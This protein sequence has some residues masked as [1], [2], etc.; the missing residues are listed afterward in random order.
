MFVTITSSVFLLKPSSAFPFDS[1]FWFRRR[2]WCRCRRRCR[3]R[4][5]CLQDVFLH[6]R[7][8]VGPAEHWFKRSTQVVLHRA[9]QFV[10]F[11]RHDRRDAKQDEH[12]GLDWNRG[13]HDSTEEAVTSGENT[14]ILVFSLT[15]APPVD[16]IDI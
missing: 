5:R 11:Q 8:T 16:K 7:R 4:R 1:F 15:V 13:P 3:R 14:F 12:H 9:D 10:A 6:R 2:C